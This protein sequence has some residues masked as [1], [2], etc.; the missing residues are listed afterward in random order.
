MKYCLLF[1]KNISKLKG[2]KYVLMPENEFE[3]KI[4]RLAMK[5]LFKFVIGMF[6][7]FINIYC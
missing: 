3:H 7:L 6:W 5:K 2:D 1:V 4:R